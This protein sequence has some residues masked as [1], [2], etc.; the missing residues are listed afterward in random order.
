MFHSGSTD[1]SLFPA[2]IYFFIVVILLVVIW[3]IRRHRDPKL[4]IEC[5]APIDELIRRW[6]G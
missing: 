6:P 4:K 1:S 3:S 5:D 2:A